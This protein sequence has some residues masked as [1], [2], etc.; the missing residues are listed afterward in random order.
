MFQISGK[1][2]NVAFSKD[3]RSEEHYRMTPY[4]YTPKPAKKIVASEFIDIGQG[5]LNLVEEITQE[6]KQDKS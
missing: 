1:E 4:R 6:I 2:K 5:I 3:K